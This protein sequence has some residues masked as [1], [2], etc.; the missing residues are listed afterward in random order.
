MA[1][2]LNCGAEY[3]SQRRRM[4][5]SDKCQRELQKQRDAIRG[6][7]ATIKSVK[8]EVTPYQRKQSKQ[9]E[10]DSD[11]ARIKREIDGR[12]SIGHNPGRRIEKGSNE[13]K[14]I[15]K[16]LTPPWQMRSVG[17]LYGLAGLQREKQFR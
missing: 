5:C 8:I 6:R 1:F 17:A 12:Y 9:I 7:K 11:Q 4:F 16:T 15:V 2:C 3:T 10:T 13:W 14:E